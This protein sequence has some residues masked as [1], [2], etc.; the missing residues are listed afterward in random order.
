MNGKNEGIRGQLA[1]SGYKKAPRLKGGCIRAFD[2][3]SRSGP[4]AV[5]QAEKE[6]PQPQVLVALGLWNTK[7]RPISSSRKST[8]TPD[9]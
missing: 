2:F 7:P 5:D 3:D 1:A 6:L 9:K 8:R 4:A